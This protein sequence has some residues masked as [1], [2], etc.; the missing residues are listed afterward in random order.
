MDFSVFN[1]KSYFTL[2]EMACLTIGID[3]GIAANAVPAP[4]RTAYDLLIESGRESAI[5]AAG[6]CAW[7][8]QN[9]QT[10]DDLTP[11]LL[12]PLWAWRSVPQDGD[13]QPD[14]PEQYL[15]DGD[16]D[17]W[18]FLPETIS[19]WLAVRKISSVYDFGHG[20]VEDKLYEVWLRRSPLLPE[21]QSG[22]KPEE[23]ITGDDWQSAAAQR[24]RVIILEALKNGR[25]PSQEDVAQ[26]IAREWRAAGMV[27]PNGAP[28][29][30]STIKR[31]A[32]APNKISAKHLH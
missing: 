24:G 9:N 3:P 27:G 20:G 6:L 10:R 31:H 26:Q 5:A 29:E 1:L 14:A 32:L 11:A 2:H 23:R 18:V 28:L 4:S 17:S 12:Y 21:S 8:R 22:A 16:P 13:P 7:Y 30:A 19:D 15:S 25:T